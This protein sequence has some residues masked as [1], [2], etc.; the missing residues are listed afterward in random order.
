MLASVAGARRRVKT[1]IQNLEYR[2]QKA[3]NAQSRANAV[4]V[5]RVYLSSLRDA[6]RSL[7]P[8]WGGQVGD[9]RDGHSPRKAGKGGKWGVGGR[10]EAGFREKWLCSITRIY[11]HLPPF[12]TCFWT[13]TLRAQTERKSPQRHQ[14]TEPGRRIDRKRTQGTQKPSGRPE[15]DTNL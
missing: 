4:G 2:I 15:R 12:I 8:L 7:E 11:T 1:R 10:L 14:D 3:G 6:K 13:L 9:R 5:R